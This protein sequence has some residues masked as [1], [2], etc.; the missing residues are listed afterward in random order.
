[1]TYWIVAGV[2]IAVIA[3][4]AAYSYGRYH[5]SPDMV[6]QLTE[7]IRLETVKQYEQR[8]NDLDKQL[9]ISQT[10]YMESQKRYDNI[11][12]KLKEIKNAKNDIKPPQNMDELNTRFSNLGY[13]PIGK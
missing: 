2:M 1:M 9:K 11:I 7:Q 10:A 12:T 3:L 8:I 5:P 13:T 4:I 6:N